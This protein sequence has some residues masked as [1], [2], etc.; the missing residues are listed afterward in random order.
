MRILN[1]SSLVFM[2]LLIFLFISCKKDLDEQHPKEKAIISISPDSLNIPISDSKYY[3]LEVYFNYASE[4]LAVLDTCKIIWHSNNPEIAKVNEL[5]EVLG[6][7]T[8]ETYI[9]AIINNGNDSVKCKVIVYDEK[10]YKFRIILK[11]K[12]TSNFSINKPEEFLSSKA[13]ERRKQQNI[14][15]DESDLPIS[16]DYIKEIQKTGAI[17]VTNS[18]WLKTVTIYTAD[19]Y[20]PDQ[21][22]KLPF[23]QDVVIVWEHKRNIKKSMSNIIGNLKS[24][25]SVQNNITL[26]SLYYGSSWN[27]INLHKGQTLH[28]LGYKGAGMDI[29]VIDAGFINIKTNPS[30]SNINIKGAKSFIYEDSNPYADN[31]GVWV[32]SCMATNMPGFY[33]GTAPK[34]NYWLLRTEDVTSEFPVEQDYW[35]AAVEYADSAGVDIVNTSLYYNYLDFA[36]YTYKYEDLDGKTEMASR[37]A[38]IAAEKGIFIVCCAGN[39]NT[40]VGTPGDSPNVLTVGSVR[41]SGLIDGFTSY[42]ITVDGRIKPDVVALGGYAAVIDINGMVDFRYGTSYASPNICGLIA[43]L[44]QAYP[45]LTS[46]QLL[47]I[48][49][50]SADRYANPIIPYGYGIP[51]MQKAMQLAQK[52]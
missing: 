44:W 40:W 36:P 46:K 21:L 43:C 26:D 17:V 3:K 35:V 5:G 22:K 41:G 10:E 51:D 13:L 34:A 31:H 42:G 14:A 12:G 25:N 45:R 23:V 52:K 50:K 1:Y 38:N 47:D 9:V 24:I 37:G 2:N 49:R 48:V 19:Q 32:T 39:D 6:I 33:V 8:G 15:I 11:D 4:A 27:S 20:L 7:H 18:K 28:E 16:P 29:A 30:L